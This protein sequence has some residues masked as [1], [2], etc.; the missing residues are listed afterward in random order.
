MQVLSFVARG[1]QT[2]LAAAALLAGPA[3]AAFIDRG[4]G[5]VYDT[6]SSL[7][8]ELQPGTTWTNWFDA[9]SYVAGLT[10][11]GGGWR[12]PTLDE[13]LGLYAQIS[14]LTGC[15]DCTGDQGLFDDIQLGYWTS[16]TYWGGQD[17]AF[18]F[19]MWRPNA[20]AG[21]FQT[22]VGSATW[23]VREGA[24]LPEPASL[25]L[26]AGALG[27]LAVMRRRVGRGGVSG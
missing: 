26:V 11:D 7:D 17:G 1:M 23:A 25:A 21:L 8:W 12:L 4:N 14:A 16:Q 9:N 19:G 15:T 27:V 5:V 24:P 22:T 2:A 20:Y 13:G 10:L 6:A 18:Y 3:H